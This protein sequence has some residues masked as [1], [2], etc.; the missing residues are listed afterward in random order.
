M[1]IQVKFIK[2]HQSRE[3][4]FSVQSETTQKQVRIHFHLPCQALALEL[5]LA[6]INR[7]CVTLFFCRQN[8][9]EERDLE[10]SA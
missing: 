7:T 3:R 4:T 2:P 10:A 6:L 5:E 9:H 8:S 1:I